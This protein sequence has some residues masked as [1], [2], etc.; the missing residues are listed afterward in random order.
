[1]AV[2]T[3][4]S[5]NLIAF[6]DLLAYSE[7]TKG[8]GD[9]G[10]NILVGGDKF[11]SYADHPRQRIGIKRLGLFSTAA[12]R[13]QILSRN[14]DHYAK[15]LGL[16]DFGAM[17]QDKIAIQLI[18]ERRAMDDILLGRIREAIHKCRTI[19]ASLP[20]AG[21]NQPERSMVELLAKYREFGGHLEC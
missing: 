9:D 3:G 14:Y 17:S 19:W 16:K 8:K 20:G 1:M 12:G 6:L 18:K 4:V 2:I 5:K 11:H 21:Y 13:Y 10:Y 15:Q 7:G